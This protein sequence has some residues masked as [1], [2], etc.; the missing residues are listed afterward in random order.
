MALGEGGMDIE[1]VNATKPNAVVKKH[2]YFVRVLQP[3]QI[4]NIASDIRLNGAPGKAYANILSA[5]YSLFRSYDAEL[6][7]INPLVM[8]G[9]GRFL[10]VHAE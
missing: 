10:A 9:K 5:P 6:A 2:I 7:E 8:N 1:T 3:F 4:R